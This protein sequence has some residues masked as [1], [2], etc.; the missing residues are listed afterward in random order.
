MKKNLKNMMVAMMALL[1]VLTF[2]YAGKVVNAADNDVV[3]KIIVEDERGEQYVTY[4]REKNLSSYTM[5]T[6]MFYIPISSGTEKVKITSQTF[7]TDNTTVKQCSYTEPEEF[8]LTEGEKTRCYFGMRTNTVYLY[9]TIIRLIP[10]RHKFSI[11]NMAISAGTSGN[12]RFHPSNN[13]YMTVRSNISVSLPDSETAKLRLRILNTKGQYVYQ[14]TVTGV[15]ADALWTVKWNGKASSNNAGVKSGSYVKAGN[16]QAEVSLIYGNTTITKKKSFTISKKAPSGTAG[17]AKSKKFILYTGDAEIDY[18]AEKMIKAAGIKSSMSDEKK[19]KKIYEYMTKKFTHYK[20]QKISTKYNLTSAS[21]KNAIA[22]LK[23]A[24][25]KKYKSGS[26]LYSH[27]YI[28]DSS[29]NYTEKSMSIRGG[30]CDDHAEIFV[31]LCNHVG[32]EAGKCSGYYIN[33]NRKY[34][35]HAWSYAM[36]N[37]KKYYYDVDISIQNYKGKVNYAWYKKTLKQAKKN[38]LFF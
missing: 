3:V 10:Y 33:S 23:T 18:M 5:D 32:V 37:G 16:Y 19:V 22:K 29:G 31:I 35:G 11:D 34:S 4:V 27:Y 1:A 28:V 26:I 24:T 36:I 2:Y 30:V 15:K 25:E 14:K 21:T 17:V 38:H 9:D 20:G 8:T 12:K 7:Q 6:T 13:N